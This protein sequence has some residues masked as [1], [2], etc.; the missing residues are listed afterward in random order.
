MVDQLPES[1]KKVLFR[2]DGAA[3]QWDLLLYLAK[4]LHPRFGV[5]EFTVSAEVRPQLRS[6]SILAVMRRCRRR[7]HAGPRLTT[8]GDALKVTSCSYSGR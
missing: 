7:V 2:S 1:V 4:G 6:T 3:Y 8:R 5:I